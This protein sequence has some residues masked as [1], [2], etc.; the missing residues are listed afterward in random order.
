MQ[1]ETGLEPTVS[2]LEL[3]KD[4]LSV[5]R[6]QQSQARKGRKPTGRMI[7]VAGYVGNKLKRAG[8]GE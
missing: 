8:G 5:A 1:M 4:G 3:M 2:S 6:W 7:K